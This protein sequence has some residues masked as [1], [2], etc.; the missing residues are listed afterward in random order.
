M[1]KYQE[2]IA[3]KLA[4]AI[5]QQEAWL[6]QQDEDVTVCLI[7]ECKNKAYD[8]RQHIQAQATGEQTMAILLKKFET[9]CGISYETYKEVNKPKVDDSTTVVKA[10]VAL[11]SGVK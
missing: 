1:N 3:K 11:I 5:E 2:I 7:G 10:F 4:V 6:L 8:L 9:E